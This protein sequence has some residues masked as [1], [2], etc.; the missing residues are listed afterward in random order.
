MKARTWTG[1]VAGFALVAL[2]ASP[3]AAQP[4]CAE[5]AAIID[6]LGTRY[7]ET[8]RS[9]GLVGGNRIVE[10]L[11]SE[12]TGSWTILVTDA[13]GLA[14]LIASGQHY[15]TVAAAPRGEPL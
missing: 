14:C 5:R 1:T 9:V 4:M 13:A 8:L 7:G 10:V 3:L 11:A 15:Q 6:M 12:E 2:C